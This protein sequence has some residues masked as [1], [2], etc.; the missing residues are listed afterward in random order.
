MRTVEINGTRY[1]VRISHRALIEFER[2]T[3]KASHNVET[4]EDSTLL[5][6]LGIEAS[7]KRHRITF[8]MNFEQFIDY[9]D[10]HP[11][12]IEGGFGD[13]KEAEDTPP[14]EKKSIT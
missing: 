5:L 12:I 1:P 11:E 9:C 8:D 13:D 6:Y 2:R 7:A 10:Q 4:L 14:G 3:G